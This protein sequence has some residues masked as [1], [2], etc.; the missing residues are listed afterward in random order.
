MDGGVAAET[1]VRREDRDAVAWLTLNRPERANALSRDMIAAL[2]AGL[3]A[4]AEDAAIRVAV[5]AAEGRIFCAGHDLAE[6]R[7]HADPAWQAAL[8]TE[9]S[10]L[11]Q[12]IGALR[13]PVIAC[14]QG[15]AVAAG[16]QLVASCDL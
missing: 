12:S 4:V 16:C 11:M 10:A 15:A 9:C 2:R 3:H 7:A 5:I 8:F 13:V 6:I 1:L 14:V